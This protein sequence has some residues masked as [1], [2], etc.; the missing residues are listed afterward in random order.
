MNR[1]SENVELEKYCMH[2]IR[3]TISIDKNHAVNKKLKKHCI[4]LHFSILSI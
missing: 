2:G 4:E 1:N 3:F